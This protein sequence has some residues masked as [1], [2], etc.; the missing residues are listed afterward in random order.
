MTIEDLRALESEL[1]EHRDRKKNNEN[2]PSLP[3]SVRH[4]REIFTMTDEQFEHLRSCL[5]GFNNRLHNYN[6][7]LKRRMA[8]VL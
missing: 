8:N 4:G 1:Q 6:E 3:K 2:Y 5:R 7:A